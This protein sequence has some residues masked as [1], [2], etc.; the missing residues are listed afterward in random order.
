MTVKSAITISD[1]HDLFGIS[2][3]LITELESIPWGIQDMILLT[4]QN[5]RQMT[6]KGSEIHNDFL[7]VLEDNNLIRDDLNPTF[8]FGSLLY[9]LGYGDKEY[10]TG[11][12]FFKSNVD[13]EC[14]KSFSKEKISTLLD[15][16]AY[17]LDDVTL[18]EVVRYYNLTGTKSYGVREIADS[19]GRSVD[20]VWQDLNAA[21]R[22]LREPNRL[23]MLK[24]LY[25][26][27]DEI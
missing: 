5:P 21:K 23:A 12:S 24:A 18:W 10:I 26:Y 19:F 11:P 9:D 20:Q 2:E 15:L 25:R 6:T 22:I 3:D 14:F 8:G 17:M 13:Y 16:L 27:D 7:R 1:Y 4:R